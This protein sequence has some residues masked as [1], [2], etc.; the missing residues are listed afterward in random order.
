MVDV[1][2]LVSYVNPLTPIPMPSLVVISPYHYNDENE[3][4]VKGKNE[5]RDSKVYSR[6]MD[7]IDDPTQPL[8]RSLMTPTSVHV[9]VVLMVWISTTWFV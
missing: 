3:D 6:D 4:S 7:Y 1:K 2:L 8:P 9:M 5:D